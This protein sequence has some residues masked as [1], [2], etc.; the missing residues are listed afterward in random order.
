MYFAFEMIRSKNSPRTQAV[1]TPHSLK[2]EAMPGMTFSLKMRA[3]TVEKKAMMISAE[4]AA[5]FIKASEALVLITSYHPLGTKVAENAATTTSAPDQPSLLT[6]SLF[7]TYAY[8]ANSKPTRTA[9]RAQQAKSLDERMLNG[10]LWVTIA[11]VRFSVL[12]TV[13]P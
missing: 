4:T 5:K 13:V 10:R 11:V 3:A 12:L 7:D 9:Q 8:N 1:D 2:T 6:R